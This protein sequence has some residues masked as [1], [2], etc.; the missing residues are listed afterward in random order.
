LLI[1]NLAAEEAPLSGAFLLDAPNPNKLPYSS[2][3]LPLCYKGYREVLKKDYYKCKTT[4]MLLLE[5]KAF[6]RE[7]R[8]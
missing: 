4:P 8:K 7:I 2:N 5:G 6:G 1:E 3:D